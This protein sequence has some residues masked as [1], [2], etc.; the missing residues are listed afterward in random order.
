MKKVLKLLLLSLTIILLSPIV[1]CAAN[2][3]VTSLP[4]DLGHIN[5]IQ[6][7]Q[8]SAEK[9]VLIESKEKRIESETQNDRETSEEMI[10][11]E[12]EVT[13]SSTAQKIVEQGPIETS[14]S[15]G[16]EGPE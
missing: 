3:Y 15:E 16:S 12:Q 2:Y 13:I 6:L 8:S 10:T 4:V 5:H 11:Q 14:E 1:V 7:H 9:P